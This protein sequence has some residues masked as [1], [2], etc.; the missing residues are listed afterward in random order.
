[1]FRKRLE[2]FKNAF[3]IFYG[4]ASKSLHPDFEEKLFDT[5]ILLQIF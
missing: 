1:M 4:I 5:A 2:A 3:K